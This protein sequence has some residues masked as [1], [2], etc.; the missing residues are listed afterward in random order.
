V[1]DGESRPH[2][3]DGL[4]LTLARNRIEAETRAL[5]SFAD[6]LLKAQ[7]PVL[8]WWAIASALNRMSSTIAM[9][10]VLIIGTMLVQAGQ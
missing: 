2:E 4:D 7:Y 10:V 1:E 8:D 6:R 3:E 5:K 9:M